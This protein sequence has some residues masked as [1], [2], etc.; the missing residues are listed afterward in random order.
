MSVLQ[1]HV[2]SLVVKVQYTFEKDQQNCLARWPHTLQIQTIPIDDR[3]AIGIIDL[4]TCL[5]ALAQCSPEIIN[6][7]DKDYAVYAVDYSEEDVPMVGQG[8]LSWGLEQPSL[9]SEPKLVTG[10]VT[11]NMLAA[12]RGGVPETLEVRLK[13]NAVPRM[14]R[15][16]T[17]QNSEMRG[18]GSNAPTPT[19]TDGNSE[20]SSLMQSNSNF[21]WPTNGP[22]APSP[23][24][25]PPRYGSPIQAPSP[26]PD[27]RP[28]MYAPHPGA[29]TPPTTAVALAP[30]LAPAP[31][32]PTPA[33]FFPPVPSSQAP[34][35]DDAPAPPKADGPARS[36]K[37]KRA[38]SKAPKKRTTTSTGNPRGRPPKRRP[39]AG[40]TSAIEDATDAEEAPTEGRQIKRAKTFKAD[41]PSKAPLNSAPGSLRV[42]ASTSGSL[43][44][45]RPAASGGNGVAGTHLQD[46]PRAPTPVPGQLPR[47]QSMPAGPGQLRRTSM[48]GFEGSSR[49]LVSERGIPGPSTLDAR[50]PPEFASQSPSQVYTP[51]GESPG[52][53]GSSP[54]VPRSTNSIRS[55]PP[56]S[57]PVL[58]P[59]PLPQPQPDSGFM[60]GGF[61]EMVDEEDVQLPVPIPVTMPQPIAPGRPKPPTK[62]KSG[63]PKR[64]VPKLSNGP[65]CP[66]SRGLPQPPVTAPLRPMSRDTSVPAFEMPTDVTADTS[67]PTKQK[68]MVIQREYPG[69]QE[70]LPKKSIY[71]PAGS[72]RAQSAKAQVKNSRATGTT[73]GA[74]RPL[75]RSN[76]EPNLQ[77][78]EMPVL[79]TDPP[80]MSQ[81]PVKAEPAEPDVQ[82]VEHVNQPTSE[83]PN[84]PAVQ[85]L[86][87]L[88]ELRMKTMNEPEVRQPGDQPTVES[89]NG[90]VE[91]AQA[92]T[93]AAPETMQDTDDHLLRLLSEPMEI[94]QDIDHELPQMAALR[95]DSELPQPPNSEAA[96]PGFMLPIPASDP[97]TRAAVGSPSD[98]SL[99]EAVQQS[100]NMSRKQSI[101]KKL[102]KAVKNGE[103][104]TFCSNCGSISTPTW[105]KIWTQDSDGSPDIPEYSDKPGCI[106][107]I[108]ILQRDE[109]G[110]PTKYR[111][112]KKALGTAESSKEWT[113]AILCNRKC[114]RYSRSNMW[115][116]G[117][118]MWAMAQ[119]V[120]DSAARIQMGIGFFQDRQVAQE[121]D[122]EV[123]SIQERQRTGHGALKFDFRGLF[124]H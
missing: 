68:E 62:S 3:N 60:S 102:E 89:P 115:T 28:D 83:S 98:C 124:H 25:P 22:S 13:L 39:D 72:A 35:P 97:G 88:E 77:R 106:T 54:P 103:M 32:K 45:M 53:L 49:F 92:P 108:V 112:V 27:A 105:R 119:Q 7:P 18:Y 94:A 8:M 2:C 44:T 42:A 38:S 114:Y 82:Q 48:T 80:P 37:A 90:A 113:E 93:P 14:Q 86:E 66:S 84:T 109:N 117:N 67:V 70:L 75:K 79:P 85:Q 71:N 59:M 76:T 73:K 104:P 69:P 56:R 11:K 40:N 64:P 51:E 81:Q 58:P 21:G 107:A 34:T 33:S 96:G 19:P 26:A 95:P 91:G 24:F 20:W 99:E 47:P 46:I 61:D 30:A 55:S 110:K 36:K 116:D 31:A 12:L 1:A 23:G 6:Q 41:W 17:S 57:S 52:D 78:Q 63:N 65:P 100:K 5:Q 9:C 121:A 101:K 4:R 87:P 50:S 43:R 120:P 123:V 118:S 16:Q 10:R 122:R 111:T 29:P 74:A 15:P